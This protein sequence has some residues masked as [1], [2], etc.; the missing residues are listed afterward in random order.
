MVEIGDVVGDFELKDHLDQLFKTKEHKGKKILLSF[1]PFAW[2]PVCRDQMLSIEKNYER[3]QSA[4]TVAVGVSIDSIFTKK[5]WA[6][7]IGIKNTRLLCDFWPHGGLALR[8]GIFRHKDGFSERANIL[9]DE[10]GCVK[11]IKVY[12]IHELPDIDELFTNL[13]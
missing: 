7:A 9:I 10:S 5:A 11:F 13:T 1:H 4:N 3:F 12:P 8:L 6:E 2:T